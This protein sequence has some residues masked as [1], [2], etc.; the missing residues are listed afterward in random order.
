MKRFN[1]H[2][3]AQIVVSIGSVFCY[4]WPIFNALFVYRIYLSKV[5][6][7]ALDATDVQTMLFIEL[8]IFFLWILSLVLFMLRSYLTKRQSI[9]KTYSNEERDIWR[10]SKTDDFLRFMKWEA[11]TVG[12][13]GMMFNFSL[14]AAFVWV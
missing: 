8:W 14:F 7:L 5:G 2:N 3:V 1:Q 10:D 12:Y 9:F 6:L 11:F 4:Y 13:T